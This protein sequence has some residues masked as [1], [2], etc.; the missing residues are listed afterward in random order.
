[1]SEDIVERL[2]SVT[3]YES[4]GETSDIPEMAAA[5]IQSLRAQLAAEKDRVRVLFEACEIIAG[6][7]QCLDNL[8]GNVD[9]AE[10]ALKATA[11]L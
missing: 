8:M 1:M 3:L 4:C 6:K 5:E 11:P 10:W 9:V 7:R 2:T